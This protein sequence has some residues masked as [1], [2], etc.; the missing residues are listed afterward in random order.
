MSPIMPPRAP[1]CWVE[2]ALAEG[3]LRLSAAEQR[4]LEKV[5]RIRAGEEVCVLNGTGQMGFGCLLE[6][7]GVELTS[8]IRVPRPTPEL[9]LFLGAVKH[10]AWEEV[11]RHAT[12]LGVS[13]IVRVECS[14][15]VSR[16]EGK[17]EK[18]VLRWRE[19]LVEACKQSAN[20]W[21]PELLLMNS[22]S[23]ALEESRRL[24]AGVVAQLGGEPKSL[25]ETLPEELPDAM[26][27]WIGPEGDFSAEEYT[28]IREAGVVP[29]SLGP[30]VLRTETAA[31]SLLSRLR[32][33]R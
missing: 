16:V 3:E 8:V 20:P 4:H 14:H 2:G 23:A 5:R 32:L 11:L 15:A 6:Q 26:A 18:K 29:V 21:M 9:H 10:S 31:L 7:G 1:R 13:R 17:A 30:R 22:V 19:L 24:P 28:L 25:G 27:V 33:H 12:E